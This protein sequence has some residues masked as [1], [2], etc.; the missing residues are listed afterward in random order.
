M[1]ETLTAGLKNPVQE[2]EDKLAAKLTNPE[3]DTIKI[4]D[5]IGTSLYKPSKKNFELIY[6]SMYHGE[7]IKHEDLSKEKKAHGENNKE[8]GKMTHNNAVS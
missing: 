4:K 6:N 5:D 1:R 2:I 7:D 3:D 8:M